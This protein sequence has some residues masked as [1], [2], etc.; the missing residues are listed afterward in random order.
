MESK[1]VISCR[2][3]HNL[4][5]IHHAV[6]SYEQFHWLTKGTNEQMDGWTHTA[7]CAHLWLVQYRLNTGFAV[8]VKE[9]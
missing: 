7:L 2:M 8:D 5:K 3:M 1:L 4:I 9:H 6:K